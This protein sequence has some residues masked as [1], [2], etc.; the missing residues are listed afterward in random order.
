MNHEVRVRA[1]KCRKTRFLQA[2]LRLLDI[3][4]AVCCAMVE[5]WT[6]KEVDSLLMLA[7][8]GRQLL[9]LPEQAACSQL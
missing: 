9:G 5:V 8:R 6:L 1:D 2:L 3:A 4:K 7:Q